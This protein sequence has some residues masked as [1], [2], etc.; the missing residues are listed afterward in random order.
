MKNLFSL[1]LQLAALAAAGC[2]SLATAARAQTP[3]ASPVGTW[4]FSINGKQIGLALLTF[5][6]DFTFHGVQYLRPGPVKKTSTT[7]DRRF[8]AGPPTRLGDVAA[9]AISTPPATN[10]VGSTLMNGIWTYDEAGKI[11]GLL[12]QI[13]E[14]LQL[15]EVSLTNTV[16]TTNIVG[17]LPVV[18]TQDLVTTSNVLQLVRTTNSV[19]LRASVVPNKKLTLVSYTPQGRLTYSGLPYIAL[20]DISGDYF[21]I[22]RRGGLPFVE[23]LTLTPSAEI[24]GEYVVKGTGPGYGF[25]GLAFPS[26][27]NQIAIYLQ[28][29]RVPHT[30]TLH[31][32]A[33]N[34]MTRKGSLSGRDTAGLGYSYRLIHQ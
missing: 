21:A 22:G 11:I 12:D 9:A 1:R 20:P 30:I 28:S 13:V 17:G 5:D 4:D 7:P 32:G 26:R 18:T 31:S 10:F 3:P 2:L 16:A 14:S 6:N 15:V 29:D 23:F 8:P 27:R 25:D 19:S 33:F 34:T 24:P